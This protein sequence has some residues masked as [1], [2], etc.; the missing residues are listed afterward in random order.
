MSLRTSPPDVCTPP[1]ARLY[2]SSRRRRALDRPTVSVTAEHPSRGD[3]PDSRVE[4]RSSTT[5]HYPPRALDSSAP[6]QIRP[7][8]HS[9]PGRRAGYRA[10]A[11]PSRGSASRSR[12][13]RPARHQV[14]QESR[15]R[16]T[17]QSHLLDS[18]DRFD[19]RATEKSLS[20]A[21]EGLTPAN[22]CTRS[23]SLN[24]ENTVRTNRCDFNSKGNDIVGRLDAWVSRATDLANSERV[25]SKETNAKQRNEIGGTGVRPPPSSVA[26]EPRPRSVR[27]AA[28]GASA[29]P[30]HDPTIVEQ[31]YAWKDRLTHGGRA[32]AGLVIRRHQESPR[33]RRC[34]TTQKPP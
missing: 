34:H 2:R 5:R 16:A 4:W 23:A 31:S 14:H 26:V 13:G 12:T 25:F 15:H 21:G 28:L 27:R 19:L 32:V 6:R 22:H 30:A 10:I 24:G 29:L 11:C 20:T 7:R 8:E 1:P 18:R 33:R 17:S 3:G 9:P